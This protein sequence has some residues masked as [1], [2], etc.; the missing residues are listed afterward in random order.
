MVTSWFRTMVNRLPPTQ[1]K[2]GTV[3]VGGSAHPPTFEAL[4]DLLGPTY[5]GV[6]SVHLPL[7]F[8]HRSCNRPLPTVT[9]VTLPCQ[10]T[11]EYPET[12]KP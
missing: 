1:V 10:C 5:P 2:Q 8:P 4:Y 3:T 9:L 12:G 6:T 7:V 11:T